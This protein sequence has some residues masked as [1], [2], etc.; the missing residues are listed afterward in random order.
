[1]LRAATFAK[2]TKTAYLD[3]AAGAPMDREVLSEMTRYYDARFS[4]P[5]SM[6]ASGRRAKQVIENARSEVAQ[7]LGASPSEIIFTGSGTEA[8]NMAVT[9]VARA[10]RKR[11]NHIIVTSVEHKAVLKP[12]QGLAKEG[13]AV[14]IA[15]VDSRGQIDIR[16]VLSLVRK[17]T[18]LLSVMYAN[19]EI[20]TV[21]PIAE[22]GNAL[23][24]CR[25][26]EGYPY[27]HTDACQAAGLLSLTV[28]G[29]GVDLMTLNGSK[30]YGPKG[31]GVL[32]KR[33]GVA[34]EPLISGGEQERN[35][36]AGTES[37]PLIVG[38][39]AA[40]Q[41]AERMRE[42]ETKRLRALREYFVAG[43]KQRIP[44]VMIDG[45]P[46]HCLPNNVHVTVPNIEGE[47]MLLLL[48]SVGVEVSTGSACS[49]FDLKPSHVLLAIGQNPDLIHGSIR[50]SLGRGTTKEEL[51][52]VLS[53]FP[54]IV[55][56]LKGMSALPINRYALHAKQT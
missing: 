6:H 46:A 56:E 17:E 50:F 51:D 53:V 9:G 35:Q 38:M 11:D 30:I 21:Y 37:V 52:Y 15:P 44:D 27:F 4:N 32:Y 18:I 19:N 16:A 55:A 22:L 12:A 54:R 36:R 1:M 34:M 28:A 5:S 10:N 33:N 8:D 14:S 13:F 42:E 20:G 26:A 31:V 48:D 25:D 29:L 41:K 2:E 7:I 39:N 49:A 43:L 23:K 40:L 45:D 24:K 3:H 47:S